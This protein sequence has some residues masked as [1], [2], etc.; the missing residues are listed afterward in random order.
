[1][2]AVR[3]GE[4]DDNGIL[5]YERTLSLRSQRYSNIIPRAWCVSHTVPEC[6]LHHL[7]LITNYKDSVNCS[8]KLR[9]HGVLKFV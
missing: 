2:M 6:K 3:K 5:E 8:G 9:L 4:F 1:M 7:I